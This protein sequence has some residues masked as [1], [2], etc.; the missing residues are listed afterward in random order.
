LGAFR[1]AANG[2]I[3]AGVRRCYSSPPL[4]MKHTRFELDLGCPRQNPVP[5]IARGLTRAGPA[6]CATFI[7]EMDRR[8]T[9][10]MMG[11]L[12]AMLTL[13][14]VS[15][16]TT[17]RAVSLADLIARSTRVLQAT[18]L[19]G[20]ARFEDVGGTRHIVTYTRLRVD[21][22]ISGAPNEPEILVRT[23]GGHVD[24][25]G[26]IVHGEAQ[27][28]PN[29]ACVVFL[30][31]NA[32]GIDE[33]TEM[34]QGHYPLSSDTSGVLRLQPSRNVAHLV[35]NSSSPNIAVVRL[36]GLQLSEARDLIRGAGR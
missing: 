5:L 33:V 34:A 31:A 23:L 10:G 28:I 9:L 13:P 17:A 7:R 29:E 26:E 24:K 12:L 22:L 16:A 30:R 18:P 25:L 2:K 4:I 6:P 35:A 14:R 32:D 20:N 11:T 19:E 21:E 27:L 1:A 36:S 3:P 8:Q 15:H